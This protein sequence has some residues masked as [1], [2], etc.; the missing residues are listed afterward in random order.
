[1]QRFIKMHL[2]FQKSYINFLCWLGY[3]G[4]EILPN[5]IGGIIINYYKDHY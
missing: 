5:Y 4:D 1:M 2:K 3:I